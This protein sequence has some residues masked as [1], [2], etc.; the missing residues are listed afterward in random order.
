M[1]CPLPTQRSNDRASVLETVII[2]PVV[3]LLFFTALQAAF[4]FHARNVATKAALAGLDQAAS[5]Y[6]NDVLGMAAAYAYIA[7]TAPTTLRS[8]VV[9]LDRDEVAVSAHIVGRPIQLIPLLNLTVSVDETA[10][11]ERT[12]APGDRR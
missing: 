4:Y 6:G 11:I 7:E 10:P 9:V 1:K 8:P 5:E 12:T 2:T 3:F